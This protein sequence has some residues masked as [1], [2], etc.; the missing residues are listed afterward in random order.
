[1]LECPVCGAANP[2]DARFCN[3]CGA[4]IGDGTS[5]ATPRVPR[6]DVGERRVV[7]ML[8]CDVRG[9]TSMAETLDP[10][11]W[12]D[13]MNAAFERLIAPVQRH[14]GTVARLMGDAILAFFGAPTAHEDDP[15]RAVMAGLEIVAAVAPFRERLASER[16]LDLD[17]RV[18]INTGPVVVG[19]VGAAQVREYSAMGDAVNVAARMEQT[20]DPGTVRITGA[21][22]RLVADLFDA[23][24]LGE[25][26]VKGKTR[27][28]EAF[29]VI[30]RRDAPWRVRA[31]RTLEAP[32]VGRDREMARIDEALDDGARGRG[33]VV[34]LSG[35]PGIGKSRLVEEANARWASRRPDDDRHWDLW[36]C[37]PYDE[38]QP[39]A[40]YR[41]QVRDRAG[42]LPEDTADE[43]RTK[44]AAMARRSPEGWAGTSERVSRALLGV[45]LA[46][47]P[48][49][50]GEAFQ[51]AAIELMV[52]TTIAL[53]AERL[54]VF[55][56][57]H[58]CDRASLELVRAVA[59]LVERE[60]IVVLITSR[61]DPGAPSWELATSLRAD[62]GEHVV[63]I[64]LDPLS[65]DAAG[66]LIA[67]LLPGDGLA[68][69]VR[70]AILG[71]AEGNPLFVHEVARS[72]LERAAA[73]GGGLTGE[74][75]RL[76]IPDT[77]Q[78]LITV[79]L[80][81]L[82]PPARRVLQVAS[83]I[84]RTFD[85]GLLASAIPPD[86]DLGDELSEL[87]RRGLIHA[88]DGPTSAY[89]FHHALTQEAAYGSLLH[90]Q[91]REIHR[92]VAGALEAANAERPEAVAPLL[93]RHFGEA[94][95][96]PATLRY[97]TIAGDAA[98]RLYANAEAAAHYATALDVARRT[99][100]GAATLASLFE[101]RGSALEL[102]GAYEEATTTY[103]AMHEAARAFGDEHM[104]LRANTAFAL[105]FATVTPKFDPERGRRLSEENAVMARRLGDR[106]AEARSLWNI[107]VANVYGGGDPE[108]AR[109]AGM[110]SLAIA[111]E[112]GER[113]QVAFTLNDLSR[114]ELA[115]GDLDA[116][117][118]RL[119]EA[120]EL[121]T[122]LDNRP[123]LGEN[124][125]LSGSIHL[126]RGGHADALADARRSFEL[127]E[128]IDNPWGQSFALFTVYRALLDLGEVGEAVA[129][130]Q[131]CRE[132]GERGGFSFAAIATRADLAHLCVTLGDPERALAL[133]EESLEIARERVPPGVPMPRV[134]IARAR[135]ALGDLDG[136]R[137]ALEGGEGRMPE[138]EV[139][140]VS[141]RAG[142]ARSSLALA[143]G[144]PEAAAAD[145]EEVL[146]RLHGRGIRIFVAEASL[147]LAR[148]R[149]VAGDDRAA[150][151][152]LGVA[153]R[154][155]DRLG[156]RLVL[157]E[158][159]T[160]SADRA[161]SPAD[162]GDLRARVRAIV[163]DVAAGIDDEGL[164]ARVLAGAPRS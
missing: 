105:L 40:Q 138:P 103:E 154:E 65:T 158:A 136:A 30:G 135:I 143:S 11:E 80:D 109:E 50:E 31:A 39:Y 60:A 61:A 25:I 106:A 113:E 9:S 131:R 145:A 28:V 77:L 13:I 29:R 64:E 76:A 58:W 62:L 93:V 153:A 71:K 15:Q 123:M 146:A 10:E 21:T 99:G 18:G 98:A 152:A 147:A 162:A 157:A 88:V 142:M 120:R 14:E 140:I 47:E 101:R 160:L 55:E 86:G 8:F 116:A 114:L 126:L 33:T 89:T 44:V 84:G 45:E 133:A 36:H 119:R 56:D 94:G 2:R 59:R 4:R 70:E 79:G 69:D 117:V 3:A 46:D 132:L 144:D 48:R 122:A 38:M 23:E 108:R 107:L 72:L 57:L 163:E 124:L 134:A 149:I 53:G 121:W 42:I 159:L 155:A 16:G 90:K 91:R 78:S 92:R 22:Y 37:V 111:R 148:A 7:T 96:D 75:V 24:P 1:M 139:T 137:A 17:V 54:I 6:E 129:T 32:L 100:E 82:E 127:G 97:A 130:I 41:R 81:R 73:E 164:R 125:G 12:T 112:L 51:R 19:D 115:D 34:L 95:D 161:P 141:A 87:E 52:G 66:E 128:V 27:P 43:V 104:Q 118:E 85:E 150:A 5:G 102:A 35:E 151:D 63:T 20:A 67:E 156:E 68:D 74:A 26:E 49:L 83:V 110:A